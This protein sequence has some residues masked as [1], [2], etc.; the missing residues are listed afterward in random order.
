[1]G[2]RGV[3]IAP[4]TLNLVEGWR[5]E[6][7]SLWKEVDI[8][9]LHIANIGPYDIAEP[10]SMQNTRITVTLSSVEGITM[11]TMIKLIPT[12]TETPMPLQ[13]EYVDSCTGCFP[14]ESINVAA[15]Q[16]TVLGK[17]FGIKT[18]PALL[19]S[20]KC[21]IF[22]STLKVPSTFAGGGFIIGTDFRVGPPAR[23]HLNLAFD[24]SG[25]INNTTGIIV[26]YGG[27]LSFDPG[28][29]AIY[30][31]TR[32]GIWNI[33]GYVH[34]F[35]LFITGARRN[36]VAQQG[37]N[38]QLYQFKLTH[39]ID[40][41]VAASADGIFTGSQGLAH[42]GTSTIMSSDGSSVWV[43]G[44]RVMGGR[45]G[46]YARKGSKI[47][48]EGLADVGRSY[49]NAFESSIYSL[50]TGIFGSTEVEINETTNLLNPRVQVG[51]GGRLLGSNP[52]ALV[53]VT[54]NVITN[55]GGWST[56]IYEDSSVNTMNLVFYV[57]QLTGDDTTGN[58][59]LT[60]PYKTINKALLSAS[61]GS[62]VHIGL[63]A[64]YVRSD[65]AYEHNVT[66]RLGFIRIFG[67]TS[68]GTLINRKITLTNN[69]ATDGVNYG[70][71]F[72]VQARE[73][74][75]IKVSLDFIDIQ[76]P[77]PPGGTYTT[78]NYNNG[79]I[80]RT[81]S[82]LGPTE[83]TLSMRSSTIIR[84][85]GAT[86][87]VINN[88]YGKRSLW[89]DAVTYDSTQAGNWI[90]GAVSGTVPNGNKFESNLATL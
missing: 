60:L 3:Q 81:P 48:A 61:A 2:D 66:K 78:A 28:S 25:T 88:I 35:N 51:G 18:F 68:T 80:S 46:L 85:A 36:L 65:S 14:V 37:Y 7:N 5:D 10:D 31:G 22:Y 49:I 41:S 67:S 45:W 76:F 86:G 82:N 8:T 38:M 58:G 24:I 15:K 53:G 90:N 70:A 47:R 16:V 72:I 74:G 19:A 44:C 64:D 57:N 1:M 33:G 20:G 75:D 32:T 40:Y 83:I 87:K 30:G 26:F 34:G 42:G 84:E 54:P 39:A 43:P 27:T 79:I 56:G 77:S 17:Y 50:G 9:G 71:G 69:L 6:N 62:T 23:L 4:N 12:N 55:E 63:L 89:V 59:S 52:G 29:L 13:R 73:I 11:G 21:H